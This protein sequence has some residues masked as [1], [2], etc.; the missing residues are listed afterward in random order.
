LQKAGRLDFHLA[1]GET[2]GK[3]EVGTE[4]CNISRGTLRFPTVWNSC[5]SP[6][7]SNDPAGFFRDRL[8]Q[9][10]QT[11]QI[12]GNTAKLGPLFR[13]LEWKICQKAFGSGELRL[14]PNRN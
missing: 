3:K 12:N 11:L 13:G 4:P 6:C 1:L 9:A 2:P 14:M 7:S 8:I 5:L 10:S